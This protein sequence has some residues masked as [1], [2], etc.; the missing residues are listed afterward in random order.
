MNDA[1]KPMQLPEIKMGKA[2][3]R[4]TLIDEKGMSYEVEEEIDMPIFKNTKESEDKEEQ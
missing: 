4:K 1:K 2:S 3:L